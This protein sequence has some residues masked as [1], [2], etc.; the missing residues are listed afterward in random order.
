MDIH[1]THLASPLVTGLGD[2]SPANTHLLVS[3]QSRDKGSVV[4]QQ[5]QALLGIIVTQ[6]LEGGCPV[7]ALVPR[8]LES[9]GINHHD[10][11]HRQMVRGESS[12]GRREK[13]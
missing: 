2:P 9:W 10:G 13:L 5:L 8:I 11:S 7:L 4:E 1:S 12:G 3:L 6:L